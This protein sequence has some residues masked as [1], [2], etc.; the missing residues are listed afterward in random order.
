LS[1][2]V[3]A[4]AG[5][6]LIL[7]LPLNGGFRALFAV[8]W[9]AHSAREIQIWSLAAVRVARIRFNQMGDVWVTDRNGGVSPVELLSGTLVTRRLAWIRVRFADGRKYGELLCGNAVKDK[10]W[11]RFQLI[12]QQTRQ[13]IGR[14]ERS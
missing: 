6:A 12:W 1:A 9:I 14:T 7:H 8:L 13:I 10:Q 4:I 2:A 11:H 5:F 3:A